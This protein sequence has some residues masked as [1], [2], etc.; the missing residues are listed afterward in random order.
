MHTHALA[1]GLRPRRSLWLSRRARWSAAAVAV[2]V[3]AVLAGAFVYRL[4]QRP[5]AFDRLTRIGEATFPD[6]VAD[7]SIRA[8]LDSSRAFVGYPTAD[9]RFHLHAVDVDEP[10]AAPTWTNTSLTGVESFYFARGSVVVTGRPDR[11]GHRIIT[12]LNA[13]NGVPF[14]SLD[15]GRRRPVGTRREILRPIPGGRAP[16]GHHRRRHAEGDRHPR[17]ARRAAQ[18]L[19]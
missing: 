5:Y 2:L 15:V 6:A 16:T 13:S 3:V 17:P 9:G 12:L 4:N 10:A 11:A 18:L 8:F 19:A 7:S 14:I 1:D